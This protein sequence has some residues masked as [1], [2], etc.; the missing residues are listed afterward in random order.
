MARSVHLT[1]ARKMLDA[2]D[3]VDLKVW[4]KNGEIMVMKNVRSLRYSYR[5]GYR[6]IL[7]LTSGEK[8]RIR[9]CL[10]FEINGLEVFI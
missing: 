8:R 1:V 4:K 9:D 10:I 2:H 5:G 7:F 3:P 6:T